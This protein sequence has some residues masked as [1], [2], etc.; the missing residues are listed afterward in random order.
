MSTLSSYTRASEQPTT[1]VWTES[2]DRDES[3]IKDLKARL[4]CLV[5]EWS[6]WVE[7]EK[8]VNHI[9]ME[10]ER[11]WVSKSEIREIAP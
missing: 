10:L 8:Y 6:L 11:L 3:T 7:A 2:Q 4:L 1:R 9:K 5:N